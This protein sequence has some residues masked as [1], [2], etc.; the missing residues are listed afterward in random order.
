VN[1]QQTLGNTL[2]FS[3]KCPNI[4]VYIAVY[5]AVH[6]HAACIPYYYLSAL[7][8]PASIVKSDFQED[9]YEL[10]FTPVKT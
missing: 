7:I 5:I 8:N 1:T 2:T 6:T 10:K 4:A 3:C 9:F